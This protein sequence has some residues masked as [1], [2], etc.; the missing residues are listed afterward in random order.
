L[1]EERAWFDG[2]LNS[3]FIDSF[4]FLNKEPDNYTW[5]TVRVPTARPSNKGWRIDYCLVS[6]ALRERIK[7]HLFCPKQNI[8]IIVPF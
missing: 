6:E 4:R 3:G 7:E 2:F 1:P 8:L 5:W